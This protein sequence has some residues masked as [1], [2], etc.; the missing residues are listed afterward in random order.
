[1]TEWAEGA[2]CF[3]LSVNMTRREEIGETAAMT[4]D[5]KCVAL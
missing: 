3:L 4:P 1:M 2:M 5:C